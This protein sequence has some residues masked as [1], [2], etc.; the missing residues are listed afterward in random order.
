[1]NND[2]RNDDPVALLKDLAETKLYCPECGS[3]L[4]LISGGPPMCGAILTYEC[5]KCVSK[6]END[7][8]GI[9]ARPT[10]LKKLL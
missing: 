8:S 9:L 10:N 1:M 5:Q 6:W 2:K 4:K 3:P 7:Q